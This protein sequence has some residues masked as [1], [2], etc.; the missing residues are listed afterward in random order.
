MSRLTC[1]WIMLGILASYGA[2]NAQDSLQITEHFVEL[3]KLEL[4]EPASE[5]PLDTTPRFGITAALQILTGEDDARR[6]LS[7]SNG[8]Q[9]SLQGVTQ[10]EYETNANA[11]SFSLRLFGMDTTA[12]LGRRMVR[13][14]G[15]FPIHFNVEFADSQTLIISGRTLPYDDIAC[16]YSFDR[17]EYRLELIFK[18]QSPRLISATPTE[19]L[20]NIDSSNSATPIDIQQ[21]T[22]EK[23][24]SQPLAYQAMLIDSILIAAIGL[25][26]ILLLL[27]GFLLIKKIRKNQKKSTNFADVMAKKAA[28]SETGKESIPEEPLILTAEMREERIRN[29]M[30]SKGVSY[31]EAALRIQYEAMNQDHV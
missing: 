8:D 25:G 11:G 23:S 29:M 27:G 7:V 18:E 9:F 10:P 22:D 12:Y 4:I 3:D 2:G 1:I 26:L 5:L 24:T 28:E 6:W 13:D 21:P 16:I 19:N 20:G 30:E 15:H 17:D 14:H 31:D